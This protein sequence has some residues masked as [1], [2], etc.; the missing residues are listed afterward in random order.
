MHL[1]LKMKKKN[2]YD[3]RILR[4][5]KKKEITYKMWLSCHSF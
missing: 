5:E 1:A 3:L 4:G 2:S